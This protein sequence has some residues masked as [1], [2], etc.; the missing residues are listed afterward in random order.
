MRSWLKKEQISVNLYET[1]ELKGNMHYKETDIDKYY[2]ENY[3]VC[4]W[5]ALDFAS[6][7]N[8]P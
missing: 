7:F 8:F 3:S 1:P 4:V 6:V 5:S 2:T